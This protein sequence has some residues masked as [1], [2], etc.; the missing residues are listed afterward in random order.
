VKIRS[1]SLHGVEDSPIQE[2]MALNAETATA[3]G[4]TIPP[5]MYCA[6]TR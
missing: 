5:S 3:P 4:L 2:V 1:G 6:P